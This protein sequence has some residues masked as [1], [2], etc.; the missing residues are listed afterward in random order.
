MRDRG[1]KFTSSLDAMLASAGIAT[2]QTPVAPPRANTFAEWFVCTVR[3]DCLDHLLILSRRHL[4]AVVSEY[5]R[6][7]NEA[8]LHRGLGLEQPLP[9]SGQ[10]GTDG[11]VI[12]RDVLGGLIHEYERDA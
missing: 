8:K 9:R 11:W 1:T 6:H 5:V 10:S 12:R 3:E 4:E 7:Y 2:V